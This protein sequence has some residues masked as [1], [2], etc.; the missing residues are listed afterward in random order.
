VSAARVVWV[1]A[2][3][4][5]L[6]GLLPLRGPAAPFPPTKPCLQWAAA[7]ACGGTP[8]AARA[9]GA[10]SARGGRQQRSGHGPAQQ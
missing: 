1:R 7:A 10:H 4:Q 3:M 8:R 6:V 9:A 5:C 2:E